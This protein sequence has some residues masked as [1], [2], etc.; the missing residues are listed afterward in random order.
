M[1]K[2]TQ[3]QNAIDDLITIMSS[4]L[5][6]VSRKSSFKQVNP[7]IPVT[8]SIPDADSPEVFEGL[9]FFEYQAFQDLTSFVIPS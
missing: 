1:D 2:L 9:L 3:T 6:Y 5:S 8:Q 4:T 7:D